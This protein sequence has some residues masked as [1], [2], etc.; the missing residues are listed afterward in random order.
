MIIDTS[1]YDDFAVYLAALWNGPFN[2]SYQVT[3]H[4]AWRQWREIC[5]P[6]NSSVWCCN[7]LKQAADHYSWTGE[8][9]AQ[10]F[11]KLSSQLI[12]Q[13][14]QEDDDGAA[15]TCRC[16]FKWGGVA[17]NP[18]DNSR[19]WINEQLEEGILTKRLAEARNLLKNACASLDKYDGK[20]L[21]MNSAM[22]KI[23]AAS[24]PESL[25]IYDGRVGAALGL[26]ARDYLELT[27]YEGGPPTH[28]AFLWGES[29]SRHNPNKRDPST[30]EFRF[31]RLFGS[32][33]ELM[34]S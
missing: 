18:N 9:A 7:S 2:H 17:Q 32:N 5:T 4:R 23:Y 33:R 14:D 22:T 1:Q 13:I 6:T 12:R 20:Y 34:Q 21:R 19:R 26:L 3:S 10:A 27:K 28:L 31:P 29:R 16:I 15:S 30:S 24:A 8:D 11:L 25:I